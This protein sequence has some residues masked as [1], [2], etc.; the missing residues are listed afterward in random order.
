MLLRYPG[1]GNSIPSVRTFATSVP[2]PP[3]GPP[4]AFGASLFAVCWTLVSVCVVTFVFGDVFVAV[5]GAFAAVLVTVFLG[6]GASLTV[7]GAAVGCVTGV[8]AFDSLV[9]TSPMARSPGGAATMLTRYIGGSATGLLCLRL[10]KRSVATTACRIAESVKGP[11]S[12]DPLSPRAI[13]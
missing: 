1:N 8:V 13:I 12:R 5:D 10:T 7:D 3:V 11:I 2:L 9:F 4:P 6:A